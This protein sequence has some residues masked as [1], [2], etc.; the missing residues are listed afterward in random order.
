M[1]LYIALPPGVKFFE[2]FSPSSNESVI[3]RPLLVHYKH[4]KH[5]YRTWSLYLKVFGLLSKDSCRLSPQAQSGQ[6]RAPA[7]RIKTLTTPRLGFF[8]QYRE[9]T[10]IEKDVSS[11]HNISPYQMMIYIFSFFPISFHRTWLAS[12]QQRKEQ[13]RLLYPGKHTLPTGT[14]QLFNLSIKITDT[15]T[16][17]NAGHN[18]L[19]TICYK[20]F[21]SQPR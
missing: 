2:F 3:I 17:L 14:Q 6:C 9:R 13:E 16:N 21:H 1:L 11:L 20:T 4:L 12:F 19:T 15:H 5:F 8:Q 7:A 10:M 18:A